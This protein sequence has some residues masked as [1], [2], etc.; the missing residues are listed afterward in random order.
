[1]SDVSYLC[2]NSSSYIWASLASI[3]LFFLIKQVDNPR[4]GGKRGKIHLTESSRLHVLPQ[5][6]A[7]QTQPIGKHSKPYFCESFPWT[8]T[9][10]WMQVLKLSEPTQCFFYEWCKVFLSLRTLVK[11][12]RRY[13]FVS[14]ELILLKQDAKRRALLFRSLTSPTFL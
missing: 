2:W 6:P 1:M 10:P 9:T 12:S 4:E 5:Y 11:C 8:R 13:R 14:G 3:S 7:N